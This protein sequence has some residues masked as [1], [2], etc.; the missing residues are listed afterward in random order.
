MEGSPLRRKGAAHNYNLS[1]ENS[2]QILSPLLEDKVD[3]GMG[4]R[5]GAPAYVAWR[6]GRTNLCQSQLYPTEYGLGLRC[7]KKSDILKHVNLSA[8]FSFIVCG[9]M[10]CKYNLR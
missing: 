7:R 6:A 10:Y 4:C 5:T 3:F 8:S 1:D 2:S 9:Y